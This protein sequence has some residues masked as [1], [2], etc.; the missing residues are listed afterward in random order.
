ML[1]DA[2]SQVIAAEMGCG[3]NIWPTSEASM[4]TSNREFLAAIFDHYGEALD[5]LTTHVTSFAESPDIVRERDPKSRLSV[6][7]EWKI[8]HP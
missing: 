7:A 8:D 6:F 1:N 4:P 3:L 2:F 5:G